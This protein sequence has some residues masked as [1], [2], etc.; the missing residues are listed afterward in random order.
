MI[1][2]IYCATDAVSSATVS[3]GQYT[4]RDSTS[5]SAGCSVDHELQHGNGVD[6]TAAATKLT[7]H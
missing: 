1:V 3:D 6:W 7:G 5:I 4:T 2:K